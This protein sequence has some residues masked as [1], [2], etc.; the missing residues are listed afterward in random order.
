MTFHDYLLKRLENTAMVALVIDGG[1]P[2]QYNYWNW[3]HQHS[4]FHLLT[5]DMR[6]GHILHH[7]SIQENEDGSVTFTS[8]LHPKKCIL[9]F[10]FGGAK[11]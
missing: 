9:N 6:I 5:D 7:G 4:Q 11:L 1:E 10:Y 3:F 2:F 8:S